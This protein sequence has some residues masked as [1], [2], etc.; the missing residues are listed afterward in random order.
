MAGLLL[1]MTSHHWHLIHDAAYFTFFQ[2]TA[3]FSD[4]VLMVVALCWGLWALLQ[5]PLAWFSWIRIAGVVFL[6]VNLVFA[7]AQWHG[8]NWHLGVPH[9]VNLSSAE[10]TRYQLSAYR[11]SG[12]LGLD[13][14][15]GAYAVAWVPILW[16]WKRWTV[17]IPMV[18]ILL[19]AKV[20]AWVGV[21]VVVWWLCPRW[22][23]R[24]VLVG[25]ALLAMLWCTDGELMK[26]IPMRVITWWHTA[27]GIQ[28]F[29][30][31]GVGFH[32]I[33]STMIRQRF[34]YALPG[35]HSD[36]LSL[37]FHAGIVLALTAMLWVWKMVTQPARTTTSVALQASLAAIAV[38]SL[39]QSVVSHARIAGLMM[40]VI[41]WSIAEQREG[42]VT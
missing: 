16:S 26:K 12:V 40:I 21:A 9:P 31:R 15:L 8:L 38:M 13:R 29:W 33:T 20:T 23:G 25:T 1:V 4:G 42:V 11:A 19:A 39:G 18:C 27:Q 35:L 7:V 28:A 17:V 5:I 41:A 2:E 24:L 37:A 34:G 14:S 3:L 22:W 32:P 10:V 6:I 30:W 36:W